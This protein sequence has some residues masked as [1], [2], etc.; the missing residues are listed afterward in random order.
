M[1]MI[2]TLAKLSIPA[3]LT[4]SAAAAHA[5]ER[6]PLPPPP[7]GSVKIKSLTAIGTG[8]PDPS[9]YSTN[10]SDD[11]QAFTITFSSFIA[12]VGPGIPLSASRKNCAMT[13]VLDVPAGYTYSVGT[14]NY[15][16]FMDLAEN[17]KAE[18]KTQYS[19][20]G[21]GKTGMFE[22]VEVGA[23]SKD[24]V[25]T[26]KIGLTTVYTPDVWSPCNKERALVINPSIR[27]SKLPGAAADAQGLITN[28]SVDGEIQQVFG[29]K[30][31]G[32]KN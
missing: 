19:F 9:T 21:Q 30:W 26:D 18:H 27:V 7:A 24:F 29:F 11:A 12:E 13:V 6:F 32:C 5:E 16:G 28:D 15:R 20:Q 23:L 17:V 22:A 3:L 1:R 25:Y 31:F 8:C 2:S 4:L 14:F 10:L